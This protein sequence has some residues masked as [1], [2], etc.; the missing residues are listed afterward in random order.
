MELRT[1]PDDAF[2]ELMP[3][4]RE[5]VVAAGIE[6]AE[7]FVLLDGG[8]YEDESFLLDEFRDYAFYWSPSKPKDRIPPHVASLMNDPRCTN[9]IWLSRRALA[10]EDIHL[11]WILAH[12]A[13]HLSQARQSISTDGVRRHIQGLRRKLKFMNLPGSTLAPLE[14]D[15]DLFALQVASRMFGQPAIRDFFARRNLPRCPDSRYLSFMEEL[16]GAMRDAGQ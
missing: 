16:E 10:E 3:L 15:S 7:G 6:N 2:S 1:H 4:M 11:V 8:D 12:E 14:V 13:R 9:L 5:A